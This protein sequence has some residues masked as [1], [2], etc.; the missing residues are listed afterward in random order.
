MTI[1]DRGKTRN[2]CVIVHID[3]GKSA[4]ADRIIEKMGFLTSREMWAQ[5]LDNMELGRGRG[6][7]IK[8]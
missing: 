7:I 6:I 8:A 4:L 5:V 2:F 1:V 3:H